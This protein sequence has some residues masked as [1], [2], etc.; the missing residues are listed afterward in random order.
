MRTSSSLFF[1]VLPRIK[2][3]SVRLC[4]GNQNTHFVFSNFFFENLAVYEKIWRK[5]VDPD[6]PNVRIWSMPFAC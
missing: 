5:I 1:S 6:T 2:S 4:R 3:I